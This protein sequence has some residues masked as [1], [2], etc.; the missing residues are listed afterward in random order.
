M[1]KCI[2]IVNNSTTNAELMN[3]QY[4]HTFTISQGNRFLGSYIGTAELT[5]AY[6][7]EKVSGWT[8]AIE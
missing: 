7:D 5:D 6:V 4:Q 8:E 3:A 1:D 2:V